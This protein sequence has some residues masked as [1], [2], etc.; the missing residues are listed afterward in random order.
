MVDYV[1]V[2]E[3]A[4]IVGERS[5]RVSDGFH[6]GWFDDTKCPLIAGRRVIPFGYL[7]AMAMILRDR[8]RNQSPA[9]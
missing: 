9:R 2:A 7:H 3:A 8:S 6:K 1:G 5:R 4:R